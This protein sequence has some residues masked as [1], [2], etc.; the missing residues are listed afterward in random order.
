MIK[1]TQ[2][3]KRGQLILDR[4]S[5][6]FGIIP[7]YQAPHWYTFHFGIFK[8]ISFPR[9]GEMIQ[10]KNYKGFWFRYEFTIDGFEI[11]L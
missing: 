11:S 5:F 2:N 1:L 7:M 9:E 3:L 10:K 8:M 6:K 4:W